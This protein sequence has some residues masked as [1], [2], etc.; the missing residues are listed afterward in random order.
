MNN[1]G[2]SIL[3]VGPFIVQVVLLGLQIYT[4]RRTS[5]YSLVLLAVG[6]TMG[7]LTYGLGR[8]LASEVLSEPVRAGVVDAIFILYVVYMVLGIW[9]AVALFNSYCRLTD[10]NKLLTARTDQTDTNRG[11]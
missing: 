3:S 8:I 1:L 7:I 4:Y 10:A 9:G 6:T 2:A 11:H 5:H